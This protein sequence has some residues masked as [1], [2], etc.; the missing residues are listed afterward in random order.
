MQKERER[1]QKGN[2]MLTQ[3]VEKIVTMM[4]IPTILAFMTNSIYSIADTFF[5]SSLGTNA[6]AAVS[7]NSSLDQFITMG[8][9][10]LAVGANS[11]IARLLGARQQDKA[12]RTFS[13]AFFLALA[14]GLI[15][16]AGGLLFMTPMVRLLGATPTCEA[17]AIDY[18]TYILL[19]APF[20]T[21]S[22]VMNQC[23]RA[24][25]KATLAMIGM[26]VGGV[27]NCILDPIFIFGLGL[28]VA[29]ASM[30][31]AIS[32]LVGFL[33]LLYPYAVRKSEIRLSLRNFRPSRRILEEIVKIGSSSMFRSLL[34]VVSSILL[35]NI[36]GS[37]SDSVLAGIGISTRIMMF[38]FNII[39]GFSS[40]F[41]PV[42]GYNW[43]AA[44]YDRVRTSY[45]FSARVAVIGGIAMGLAL[46]VTADPLI[47]LFSNVDAQT[48]AIGALCI[49]TQCL[50]LPV[51]GWVAMVNMF[52]AGL[53]E[54]RSACLLSTSRQ[55]SCF[56]PILYPVSYFF[57]ADGLASVQA[58]AD[59]LSLLLAIPVIR[60]IK[61]KISE[62]EH[63]TAVPK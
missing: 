9:S 7:V 22:F 28:E 52:C 55:G 16:M 38:P 14:F 10:L 6:A 15:L 3:P 19:A 26:S 30:A 62:A 25:G 1:N 2:P 45:R 34:A 35:N 24:E 44:R 60:N 40:G 50:M 29:G 8:G 47:G 31:T 18:A 12:D 56:I 58:L 59:A 4:A 23:L 20:M 54:A 43:G 51:H 32:K 61:R 13:T 5:V 53:G 63:C 46:W 49:R 17:Y 37:I 39:L 33:V 41:Q 11:Y 57:G 36:A 21:T 42:A 27:L 48:K